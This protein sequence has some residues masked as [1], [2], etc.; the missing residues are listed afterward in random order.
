MRLVARKVWTNRR[1]WLGNLLPALFFLPPMAYGIYW[2][3]EQDNIIGAGL[4]WIVFGTVLGWIGLNLFGLIQNAF[5]RREMKRELSA[6]QIE[7]DCPHYFV[8]F[9]SP[10]FFSILD[11]HEDVGF[12]FLREATLEFVGEA[13]ELKVPRREIKS[14]SFRPNIH[15]WV[16]LGRWIS[17]EGTHKGT[18][19]RMNVEPREKNILM[20]NLLASGKIKREIED[21]Q[22]QTNG[23]K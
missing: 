15:T 13:N 11:A 22:V 20:L 19:F 14:I 6:K 4:W 23:S 10:R 16:G 1:K 2:M 8:G 5:M 3:L 18:R 12:V 17:I 9:S 7:F 21:W